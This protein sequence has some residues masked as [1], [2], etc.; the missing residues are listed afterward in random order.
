MTDHELRLRAAEVL[1][2]PRSHWHEPVATM[3]NGKIGWKCHKCGGEWIDN[4]SLLTAEKFMVASVCPE[5]TLP[6][7]PL[8]VLAFRCRDKTDPAKF[9][10]ALMEISKKFERD[11]LWPRTTPAEWIEAAYIVHTDEAAARARSG[12]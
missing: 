12:K 1:D 11:E 4:E 3:I 2:E 5:I 6:T 7:E 9:M 8:E 10:F